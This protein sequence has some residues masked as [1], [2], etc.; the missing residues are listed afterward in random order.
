MWIERWALGE[1]KIMLS[2]VRGKYA[3]LPGAGG[4]VALNAGDLSASAAEDFA[5]CDQEIDDFVV[6]DVENL[7]IGSEFIIG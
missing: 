7:G 2:Q 6:N 4:G 1:A 5:R 3:N